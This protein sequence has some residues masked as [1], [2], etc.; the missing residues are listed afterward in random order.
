MLRV[1]I[2]LNLTILLSSCGGGVTVT[3]SKTLEYFSETFN[4]SKQWF[5]STDGVA[6][7]EGGPPPPSRFHTTEKQVFERRE[8]QNFDQRMTK[9]DYQRAIKRLEE[10]IPELEK[11]LGENN[12]EVG[13]TYYTI[14]SMHQLQKNHQAAKVAFKK[15]QTIFSK[16]LGSEHPRVWKLKERIKQI[17]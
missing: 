17:P 12:I 9:V 11:R 16:W 10:S 4:K 15:A 6:S 7:P 3:K 8:K 2:L 14:G 5:K 1:W 13:E